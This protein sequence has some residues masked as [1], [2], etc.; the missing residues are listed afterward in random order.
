MGSGVSEVGGWGG[1]K[2]GFCGAFASIGRDPLAHPVIPPPAPAQTDAVIR[3]LDLDF[4]TF[5]AIRLCCGAGDGRFYDARGLRDASMSQRS[6]GGGGVV[7]EASSCA[8]EAVG[9]A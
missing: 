6:R 9:V 1:H 8:G 7:G 2:V 5:R 3:N 4:L